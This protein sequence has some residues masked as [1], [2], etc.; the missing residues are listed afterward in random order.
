MTGSTNIKPA[1]LRSPHSEI[2]LTVKFITANQLQHT[3]TH[4]HT[5]THK[6][7]WDA[8]Y[9]IDN[10]PVIRYRANI[11]LPRNEKKPAPDVSS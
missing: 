10:S 8:R 7:D 11:N 9:V 2:Y 1:A 4:T 6:Y 3:H 5:C